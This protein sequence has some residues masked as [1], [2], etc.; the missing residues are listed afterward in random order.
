MQEERIRYYFVDGIRG[1][2]II[3]MVIF[4]FL[5]DVYI[6][7]EKSPAWYGLPAIHIWQQMICWTFIFVSGFVWTWGKAGNLKR[8]VTFSL[9][10]FLIS[11]ITLAIVPAQTIWFGILN[12][13]GCAV[14]LM[15]PLEK[16]LR[17]IPA[18]CGMPICFLLFLLC[19]Q[20]QFGRIGIPGL[21]QI[22]VP[23]LL[24]RIKIL[25]PLGFPYA[26]FYSSDY[27]PVFPWIFLYLCGFYFNRIFMK[28]NTWQK[29]ARR[30]LPCLSVL[31]SKTIWIYLLHQP[32]SMLVCSL[33]F[34]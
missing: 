29:C 34:H 6:V 33:I 19:R 26:G 1:I 2:A 13:M 28:H 7:Y 4:H 21:L 24:Y 10:G 27:F 20:I 11:F 32:F 14:L 31:G 12:F 25:T 8:G 3:N 16:P 9:F 15:L 17:K 30:K 23:N 5:Y 18:A 22:Q